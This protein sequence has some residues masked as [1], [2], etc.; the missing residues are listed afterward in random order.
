MTG[1]PFSLWERSIAGRYLRAKRRDGGVALIS[2]ISFIGVTL[3]VA[4]LIIVMSVMNG[5]R[6]ELLG[7]MLG[8]NGLTIRPETAWMVSREALTMLVVAIAVT[9]ADIDAEATSDGRADLAGV[10]LFGEFGANARGQRRVH[11][12]ERGQLLIADPAQPGGAAHGRPAFTAH[13][14]GRVR[15]LNA[16]QLHRHIVKLEMLAFKVDAL[17]ASAAQ[18]DDFFHLADDGGLLTKLGVNHGDV[19]GIH[20]S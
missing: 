18:G 13:P 5:F 12:Q 20:C 14:N 16:L 4:V 2:A 9:I 17:V 6:S 7:R 11:G 19:C 1:G 3:A 15:L 10:E 8:F